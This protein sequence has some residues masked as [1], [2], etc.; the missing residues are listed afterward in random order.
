MRL[1]EYAVGRR[2]AQRLFISITR[3]FGAEIDDV[4]K[5]SLRRPHFFGRPFLALA[6]LALRGRS[7]WS[8]GERELF[9]AVVSQAN[10][11]TFC[12]GTHGAIAGSALGRPVDDWRDGRFG[13]RATAAAHFVDTLTRNPD[14]VGTDDVTAARAAGVDDD[15]LTEAVYVAHVFN[16]VNRIA[17]ALEFTHPSER[18]RLRGARVLRLNGYRIPGVLLR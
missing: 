18:A 2:P 7:A 5:A 15:A 9:A 10:T 17:D 13:V 1:L 16:A 6:Q 12:V 14:S 4:G 11:C 3:S 8:V